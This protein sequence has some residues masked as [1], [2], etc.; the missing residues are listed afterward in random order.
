M[1]HIIIMWHDVVNKHN[2][3]I[4]HVWNSHTWYVHGICNPVLE[5]NVLVVKGQSF[6]TLFKLPKGNHKTSGNVRHEC[7]R[8]TWQSASTKAMTIQNDKASST[9]SYHQ[10]HHPANPV[11][12]SGTYKMAGQTHHVM[13]TTTRCRVCPTWTRVARLHGITSW[14]SSIWI[15]GT[16]WR[17]T[18]WSIA[19][20]NGR[21]HCTPIG[22]RVR[23][24][25]ISHPA[26]GWD[27]ARHGHRHRHG[28]A[29]VQWR[30]HRLWG[31]WRLVKGRLSVGRW[32]VVTIRCIRFHWLDFLQDETWKH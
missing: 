7:H 9:R 8:L 28:H 11:V 18:S 23:R 31:K 1:E 22:W 16:S 3:E 19:W 15:V 17:G 4:R 14:H 6:Q 10:C 12:P 27:S 29:A 2:L 30:V 25:W 13:N 32:A 24:H 26:I 5:K 21:W 20:I